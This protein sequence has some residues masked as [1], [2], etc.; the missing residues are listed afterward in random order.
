MGEKK[1]VT[2]GAMNAAFMRIAINE[3][4]K[5]FRKGEG[6]PFGA[7]IVIDGRVVARAHNRVLAAHDPTAHAEV[8][9]IRKAGR[10][11]GRWH[12]T[13]ADLYATCEPCPMCLAA[14]HWARIRRV[15]FGCTS[16][17]AA[18][19]GFADKLFFDSLGRLEGLHVEVVP[20]LRDECLPLF[21]EWSGRE[22]RIVY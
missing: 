12:L 2:N 9:A 18:R 16:G 1:Y 10:R 6:G 14:I 7:V 20:F 5:G 22:D 11:L 19:I 13:E 4:R 3:A 21:E 17:D 8:M 15:Y